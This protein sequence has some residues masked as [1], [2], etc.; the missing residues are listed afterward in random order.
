MACM[1]VCAG[2][3][4]FYGLVHSMD[5]IFRLLHPIYLFF[6]CIA[7]PVAM[8]ASILLGPDQLFRGPT[9][10]DYLDV[11]PRALAVLVLIWLLGLGMKEWM[12]GM[13]IDW[14]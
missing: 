2:L 5:G 4:P 3:L 8:Y 6:G 1:H 13:M 9:M 11:N 7:I 12:S 14:D 10:Q